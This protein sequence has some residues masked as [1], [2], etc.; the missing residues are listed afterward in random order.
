VCIAS[1]CS[2]QQ[3]MHGK[4]TARRCNT[5][6]CSVLQCFSHTHTLGLGLAGTGWFCECCSVLSAVCLSFTSVRVCRSVL[7]CVAVCLFTCA[8]QRVAARSSALQC[9]CHIHTL[10]VRCA[11]TR[12]LCVCCS[13]SHEYLG[14][15]LLQCVAHIHKLGPGLVAL[16][17]SVSVAACCSVSHIYSGMCVLQRVAV[18]WCVSHT[19]VLGLGLVW[20][21]WLRAWLVWTR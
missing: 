7:Q 5:L 15:C 1:C 19:Y 9:V 4:H 14:L 10:G 12:W 17:G 2:V 16:G 21:Q 11:R 8:L 18:C 20:T 6:F 3:R 13:V